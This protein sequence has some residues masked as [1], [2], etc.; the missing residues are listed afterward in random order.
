MM[1]VAGMGSS[2]SYVEEARKRGYAPTA[3]KRFIAAAKGRA[4]AGVGR[5]GGDTT[6]MPLCE[7]N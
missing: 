5:K 6:S 1:D 2:D 4:G 7:S 3:G